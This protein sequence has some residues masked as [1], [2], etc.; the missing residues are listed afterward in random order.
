MRQ[1]II[2]A[3]QSPRRAKLLAEAG[4]VF[5]V[6]PSQH[7]EPVA[8]AW[9]FGPAEYALAASYYKA[10]A[11]ADL[12]PDRVILAADTI[13]ALDGRI[14]GKP[15]DVDDARRI[16][17]TLTGTT[18]EVITGVSLLDQSGERRRIDHA[19]TRITMRR[20]TDIELDA[21]LAGGEWQGKAG[22]YAIQESADMFVT[23]IEGSRTNVV[24]LPMELVLR[25]L[26]EF[27][28]VQR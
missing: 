2:L 5:E 21:Y 27:G 19:V 7:E 3:S 15:M 6:V 10:R 23:R 4:I 9:P 25:V 11:V 8:S 16:L 13:V 1:P 24:G 12:R 28:L 18:H 17:R 14:Y 20:M 22:A 26:S